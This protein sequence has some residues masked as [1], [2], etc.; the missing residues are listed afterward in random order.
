VLGVL[1]IRG[2]DTLAA[3]AFELSKA[4]GARNPRN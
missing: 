4:A 2:L 3:S 1:E